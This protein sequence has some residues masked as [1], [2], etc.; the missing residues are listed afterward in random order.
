MPTTYDATEFRKILF[1]VLDEVKKGKSFEIKK[2]NEVVAL[3]IPVDN[4]NERRKRQ[5]E[6][7][8]KYAGSI[9]DFGGRAF[10]DLRKLRKDGKRGR[11]RTKLVV[12]AFKKL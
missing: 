5:V 1:R 11:E 3:V 7:I 6:A 10:D 4:E 9:P 2:G 8:E 12:D